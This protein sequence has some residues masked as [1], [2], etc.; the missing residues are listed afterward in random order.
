VSEIDWQPNKAQCPNCKRLFKKTAFSADGT[1][2][3]S[4]V[5]RIERHRLYWN[6]LIGKL[7]EFT[8]VNWRSYSSTKNGFLL[9]C[10]LKRVLCSMGS[11]KAAAEYLEVNPG[12]IHRVINGGDSPMLRRRL[13]IVD[14][15]WARVSPCSDCGEVHTVDHCT[16]EQTADYDQWAS[17]RNRLFDEI[18]RLENLVEWTRAHPFTIPGQTQA[19]IPLPAETQPAKSRPKSK[20]VYPPYAKMRTDDIEQARRQVEKHYPG[21]KLIKEG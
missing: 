14:K 19:V 8:A 20:R 10:E 16:K 5:A 12:V 7:P 2:C 21:Y 11:I 13:G 18:A 4:C 1:I 17:E 9:L 6:Q 15:T 3:N